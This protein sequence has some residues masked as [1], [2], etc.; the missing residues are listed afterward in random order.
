MSAFKELKSAI[1]LEI[2]YT[3]F[4]QNPIFI[5]HTQHFSKCTRENFLNENLSQLVALEIILCGFNG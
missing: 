3:L 4:L 1:T 5:N 2:L